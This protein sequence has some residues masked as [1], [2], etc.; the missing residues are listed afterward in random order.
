V[1]LAQGAL[2]EEVHTVSLNAEARAPREDPGQAIGSAIRELDNAA[3]RVADEMVAVAVRDR[4]V[5]SVSVIHVHVLDESEP[6]Q[7]VHRAVDARQAYPRSDLHGPA[8]ELRDLEVSR[9]G[10]QDAEHGQPR[11]RQSEAVRPQ[12]ALEFAGHWVQLHLRKILNTHTTQGPDRQSGSG[13]TKDTC[14]RAP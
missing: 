3:A 12:G 4:R 1:P 5:M 7:E 2:S 9:C 13:G 6:G 10:G 8:V 11:L 14:Q